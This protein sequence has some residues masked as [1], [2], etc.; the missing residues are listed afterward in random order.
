MNV[1]LI[2]YN[3]PPDPIVGSLRAAKVAD[4]L[5]SAGHRVE[6]VTARLP[7]ERGRSRVRE[8]SYGVHAVRC[9]PHPRGLYTW[10]LRR[11]NRG[12]GGA[13][14]GAVQV[15][16]APA[17]SSGSGSR[18]R[19]RSAL[20]WLGA[21]FWVPDQM[22]GFVLPAALRSLWLCRQGIDL[23]Y[24]TSPPHS[25]H[26]VGLIIKSLIGIPW[27]MELRDPWREAPNQLVAGNRAARALNRWLERRC[28]HAAD[29]IV[30]VSDGI[31]EIV[32]ERTGGNGVRPPIVARNGIDELLSEPLEPE[33]GAAFRI[34]YLGSL[35]LNRDPMPFLRALAVVRT[36]LGLG[37]DDLSVEFIGACETY[38]GMSVPAAIQDLGI[39]DV[40]RVRPPIPHAEARAAML[41]ADLLLLLAQGQP[42]QV[43]NK[44][45]EYLGARRPILAIADEDGET[46][47]ILR[48]VG[49]HYV[50]TDVADGSLEEALERAIRRV[51]LPPPSEEVLAALTT[52]RQMEALMREL[53]VAPAGAAR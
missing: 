48:E 45:Y 26:L 29:R 39:A 4:A 20:R 27:V 35:Y 22:F 1:L 52:D 53:G 2:A 41:R 46:A 32:A 18:S 49:G 38:R 37:A 3:Y 34:V 23:V 12:A 44:L 31:A 7:S 51:P 14:N 36:R 15:Q 24:T 9:L 19:L 6:V 8:D 21:F 42:A 43:P 28:L 13:G 16:K 33:P 17:G 5:R 25:T 10:W 47:R 40:A 11:R 50:V 30:A